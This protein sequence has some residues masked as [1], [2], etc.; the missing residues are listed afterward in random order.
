MPFAALWMLLTLGYAGDSLE[1]SRE[2]QHACSHKACPYTNCLPLNFV[3]T[4]S[5]F[6]FVLVRHFT[7][8][9]LETSEVD[10]YFITT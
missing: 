7:I 8:H 3:K 9:Y 5:C 6:S 4:F 1:K 2:E 10:D